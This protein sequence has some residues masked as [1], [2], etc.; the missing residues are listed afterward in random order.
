M[1]EHMQTFRE[2]KFTFNLDKQLIGNPQ[3]QENFPNTSR[4]RRQFGHCNNV[5]LLLTLGHTRLCIQTID[6]TIAI[7][8]QWWN[9]ATGHM[10]FACV[11]DDF[12]EH[13]DIQ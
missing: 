1:T 7:Q 9:V 6:P 12:K 10:E 2:K 5:P 4:S 8:L 13:L 11:I 3:I